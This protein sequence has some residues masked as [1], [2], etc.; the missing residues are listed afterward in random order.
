MSNLT[1]LL[2]PK[3]TF[4]IDNWFRYINNNATKDRCSITMGM[5]VALG[6][7]KFSLQATIYHRGPVVFLVIILTLS[8]VAK[9]SIATTANL[10]SLKRLIQNTS[11]A[12]AVIYYYCRDVGSIVETRRHRI[13]FSP[14]WDLLYW[15]DD[16]FVMTLIMWFYWWC[17]ETFVSSSKSTDVNDVVILIFQAVLL[18]LYHDA[19]HFV[20]FLCCINT[21][22]I[23]LLR[24]LYVCMILWMLCQKWRNKTEIEIYITWKNNVFL[25]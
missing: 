17:E 6:L 18:F 7:Q 16:I 22:V 14:R 1:V 10:R 21:L 13:V 25:D 3:Y 5:T 12:Y 20:I 11:T 24:M 15:W 8:T 4:V 23:L 9:H 2:L 19:M